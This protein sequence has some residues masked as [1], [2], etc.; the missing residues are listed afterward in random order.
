MASQIRMQQAAKI[1]KM[2]KTHFMISSSHVLQTNSVYI[3]CLG[4]VSGEYHHIWIYVAVIYSVYIYIQCVYIYI[5][6]ER[7]RYCAILNGFQY[8]NGR[9]LGV[10]TTRFPASGRC[11]QRP[12]SLP[13]A[14]VGGL[15]KLLD[16]VCICELS[17]N[18]G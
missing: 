16:M 13:L 15:L 17:S 10:R 6:R 12:R 8:E 2:G 18:I 14:F 7:D 11:R 9:G 4:H 5:E 3:P 1:S